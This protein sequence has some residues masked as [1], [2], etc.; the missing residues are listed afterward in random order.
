M[1]FLFVLDRNLDS[2]VIAKYARTNV[3]KRS[4]SAIKK[5]GKD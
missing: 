1:N 2:R 5:I 3:P 4:Q